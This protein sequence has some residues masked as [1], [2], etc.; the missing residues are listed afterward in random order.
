MLGN[1]LNTRT[2][3][4]LK[5]TKINDLNKWRGVTCS[6]IRGLSIVKMTVLLKLVYSFNTIPIKISATIL[7]S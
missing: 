3:H 2:R 4:E 5:T 1:E 6:W 7:I